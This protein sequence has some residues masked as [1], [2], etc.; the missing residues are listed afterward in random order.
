MPTPLTI[1]VAEDDD[2]D[3][4]FTARVLRHF[5]NAKIIR[6]ESGRAAI[7]YLAGN[8]TDINGAASPLPDLMLL[9]LKMDDVDGHE[10]LS[11]IRDNHLNHPLRVF[12]LTGSGELRD[13]ERVKASGVAVGYFVKP[14]GPEHLATIFES[15]DLSRVEEK[16]ETQPK[17]VRR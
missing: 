5:E 15:H 4:F 6:V 17:G 11:W 1:L 3:F 9:D 12:V 16:P 13:R 2:D 8:I 7:D 14:L 10:V